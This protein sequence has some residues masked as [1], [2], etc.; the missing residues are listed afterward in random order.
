MYE[1]LHTI[2]QELLKEND[3]ISARVFVGNDASKKLLEKLGF[4]HEGTLRHAVKG[5]QD[6]IFDDQLFSI[7]KENK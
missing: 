1:A 2:I 7:T 6:I 5:Y 3:I 4:T